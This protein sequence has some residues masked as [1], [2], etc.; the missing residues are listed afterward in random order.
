MYRTPLQS[1]RDKVRRRLVFDEVSTIHTPKTVS[2]D[3]SS[4]R[5][6][7]RMAQAYVDTTAT[8]E[9]V[10]FFGYRNP[11]HTGNIFYCCNCIDENVG[12]NI[13]ERETDYIVTG[14][15]K[16][17][18]F[19]DKD[20]QDESNYCD[21]CQTPLYDLVN[22]QCRLSRPTSNKWRL[23]FQKKKQYGLRGGGSSRS[24]VQ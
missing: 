14:E 6:N 5:P 7:K 2:Q 23:R 1:R 16:L 11:L 3:N 24:T 12:F 15:K 19:T 18:Q 10:F 21:T 13:S 9:I 8:Q 20:H 4:G 22:E 17:S